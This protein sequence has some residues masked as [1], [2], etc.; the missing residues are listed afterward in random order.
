MTVASEVAGRLLG[1]PEPETRDV[2]VEHDLEAPMDDGVVLLADRYSPRGAEAK[3]T[4]LARSPYG[5]RGFFGLVYGRLLAERGFQAVVQ[6]VRGTAGSGGRFEPFDERRDGRAT[7]AWL[8]GQRR[9]Q[10]PLGMA[11][12]SYLGVAQWAVAAEVGDELG[13]LALSVAASRG[14]SASLRWRW[15]FARDR[16]HL[17]DDRRTP[18]APPRDAA[19]AAGAPPAPAG[20]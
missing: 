19:P 20:R 15:A 8:R 7:V 16:A 2:A 17:D 9:H 13:A 6:S 18:G 1:L 10:G 14:P 3:P 11:G 12:A 5:R 4:V